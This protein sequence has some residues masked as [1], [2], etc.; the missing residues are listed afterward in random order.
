MGR[1]ARGGLTT[2][3]T[4]STKGEKRAGC[5]AG[6][7]AAGSWLTTNCANGTNGEGSRGEREKVGDFFGAWGK[8]ERN[9][10]RVLLLRG[11]MG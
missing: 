10:L 9:P 4:K 11:A 1:T 8:P 3:N 2:K 6:G 7:Q 5:C